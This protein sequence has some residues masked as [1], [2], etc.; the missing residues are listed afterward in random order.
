MK[1]R[2]F[3]IMAVI[4]ALVTVL[5]VSFYLWRMG[6]K[7]EGEVATRP[8]EETRL[9]VVVAT[10]DIPAYSIINKLMITTREFDPDQVNREALSNIGTVEG[11]TSKRPIKKGSPILSSYL[12]QGARL[13]YIV[14]PGKRAVTLIIDRTGAISYLVN[15][16][17][18]VDVIG[19]FERNI[20]GEEEMAKTVV[21]NAKVLATGQQYVPKE[22]GDKP[23]VVFDTVTLA[24]S[25]NEAEKL[26]LGADKASHFRLALRNPTQ[27]AR[28]WTPG[29]TPTT[30]LGKEVKETREIE[31]YKG[32]V[33]EVVESR[34]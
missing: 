18:W 15:P 1:P 2:F 8:K 12:Y 29:A 6:R 25:L 11:S 34:K 30:L 23:P 20:A 16:G 10:Q 13:A 32:T 4:I 21:Q 7:P 24:V 17:D 28:S 33:R 27:K 14:P 3:I 26:I 31:V 22:T 5:L 9:K 19:T